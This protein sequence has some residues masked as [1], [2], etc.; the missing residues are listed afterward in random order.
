M[1]HHETWVAWS[2]EDLAYLKKYAGRHKKQTIASRMGRSLGAVEQMASKIGCSLAF[3]QSWRKVTN[4][5]VSQAKMLAVNH[6][7]KSAAARAMG[8]SRSRFI[9]LI[10]RDL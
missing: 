9:Y 5:E 10:S 8:I 6:A 3:R 1:T 4:H 2:D 7:T